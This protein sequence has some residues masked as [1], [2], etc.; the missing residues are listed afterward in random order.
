MR[1]LE[2]LTHRVNVRSGIIVLA[3]IVVEQPELFAAELRAAFQTL[4]S[5][6]RSPALFRAF[7]R[8]AAL[9]RSFVTL[10]PPLSQKGEVL[11]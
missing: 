11:T 3:A 5:A 10:A 7:E 1:P 4:R 2:R 9:V 8:I 6:Q